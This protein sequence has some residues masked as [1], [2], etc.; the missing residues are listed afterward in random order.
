MSYKIIKDLLTPNPFSRPQEKLDG[1]RALIWHWYANPNTSAQ[2]NR[3]YFEN[4]KYGKTGYGSA[5][6]LI[7]L[8]GEVIQ[9]LN[10]YE[11]G[12]HIGSHVYTKRA[13]NELGSYP[14]ANTIGIECAHIDWDGNM[15]D[16]TYSTL[17]ELSAD[18]LKRHN[19]D[20]DDIWIHYETNGWKDCHRLF[21]RNPA[22]YKKAKEDV[23]KLLK[24]PL[25]KS[26]TPVAK[27]D[28]EYVSADKDGYYTIKKGD[29]FWGISKALDVEVKD[30]E[31]LNPKVD[32]GNLQVGQKIKVENVS[33]S[34]PSKTT[35]AASY[36]GNSI[37][38]YLNAIGEDASFSNRKKLA[39]KYGISNYSGSLDQ[40]LAL[41]NK[42]RNSTLT[43]SSTPSKPAPSKGNMKTDSIVEYLNS[44]GADSS[45][46]NRKKLA[47]KYGIKGYNGEASENL[48]LLD[49]MR[50]GKVAPT[51]K[52]N[53]K[54]LNL[55]KHM[56]EWGIYKLNAS[57][58][59]SNQF[60]QL[61]P[62][63]FGG[64]SY[65]V[66]GNP[67]KDLYTIQTDDFGKVNIY[68]PR[69]RD[70]SITSSPLYK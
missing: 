63:K 7:G 52:S 27:E 29:T 6:Y 41:L 65:K 24:K 47:A 38:D 20:A 40:N 67:Q 33:K 1:V 49:L 12:Y 16:E 13:L 31:K 35:P 8:K 4:R 44:I 51:P 18:I 22:K 61:R 62:S 45:Y 14:N 54:Y 48:R 26:P 21:H 19:L 28:M 23:A 39:A 10:E 59:K 43:K 64:L 50:K 11:M 60:A 66:L 34:A 55:H 25:K 36:S 68:A 3:N 2:A 70:S 17:I 42:L 56:S 58:V 32:A 37:V 9:A 46:S 53:D 5:H 15:T 57:P 69:D 30:I